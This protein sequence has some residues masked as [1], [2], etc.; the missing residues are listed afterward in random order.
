MGLFYK[1]Q[2]VGWSWGFQENA[3]TSYMCNSAIFKE[4]QRKGLYTHLM[5]AILSQTTDLGFQRI[6][7]RHMSTNNPILIAKL[8][9]D[10]QITKFELSDSFGCM[11]HLTC[12]TNPLRRKV[13]DFRSG[14]IR[15][16]A[17]L[18]EIFKI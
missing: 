2:F 17:E 1:N 4:H 16:D 5:K 7:S 13:L 3:E 6:Y 12:F 18:K 10:F 11:L 15:P 14:H 9:A 8:K